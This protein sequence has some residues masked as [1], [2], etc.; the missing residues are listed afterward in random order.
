MPLVGERLG[1]RPALDGMRAV[2]ITLVL[3][4]HVLGRPVN[5]WL[6]VDLFFVLSGF[7]ITTLLVQEHEETGRVRLQAFWARRARRLLPAL[8][9]LLIVYSV[10]TTTAGTFEPLAVLGGVGYFTNLL[11]GLGP[12]NDL[13]HLWSLAQ[14]EQFYLLWP[15]VLFVA[16]KGRRRAAMLLLLAL[17]GG[18]QLQG[19]RHAGDPADSGRVLF[20]PDTRGL[21]ILVGC[22]VALAAAEW[23]RL[24]RIARSL[25]P[26]TLIIV[27]SFAA[28]G[29]GVGLFG[30]GLLVFSVASALLI[31]ACTQSG[32][33][34]AILG[35][36]PI[37]YL[38]RISYGVYL[39]HMPL[40]LAFGTPMRG[41]TPE[42]AAA[43]TTILVAA[44]SYRFVEQPLRRRAP[45]RTAVV[46]PQPA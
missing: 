7:L 1:Y 39:W 18:S 8:F 5:G 3:G 17:I 20:M 25:S 11:I 29:G 4:Y 9:V 14:E 35:V 16:L 31:S 45:M 28:V 15:L 12:G 22:L 13:G 34:A 33:I 32:H 26:F 40:I 27:A 6:G 41:S 21:P 36:P 24:V 10:A 30:G 37:A 38:G 2:A 44:G 42:L 19:L 46:L 43:A 23:P